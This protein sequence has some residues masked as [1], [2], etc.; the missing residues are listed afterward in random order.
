VLTN[1]AFL[2]S[3]ASNSAFLSALASNSTLVGAIAKGILTGSNNYGVAIKQNQSLNFPEITNQI[4]TPGK[5]VPLSVTS[6]AGL[7]PI[8]FSS[9]NTAVAT[10]VSNTVLLL[11]GSGST[12]ITAIQAGNA[13]Y[14][15]V[16]A[17]QPLIVSKGIQS[18]NFPAIPTQTYSTFKAVTLSATSSAGLTNTTYSIANTAVGI[19]SNNIPLLEGAILL[20]EGTGTTT[21]TATNAGNTYFG[22]AS[23]TQPLNVVK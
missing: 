14:N 10:I 16:S 2:S 17:S 23:A 19:I 21:I 20:L 9:G 13:L 12:T 22:P 7:T 8:T 1:T 15:S 18:L 11:Q 5:T 3:L 4:I 6:S